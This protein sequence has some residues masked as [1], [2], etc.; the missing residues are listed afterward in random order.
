MSTRNPL[1]LW[2]TP[3][4]AQLSHQSLPTQHLLLNRLLALGLR[5]HPMDPQR[6]PIRKRSPILM[7]I[8]FLPIPLCTLKGS[9]PMDLQP[10][11]MKL[12]LLP[13]DPLLLPM[14]PLLLPMDPLHL[15][16]SPLFPPMD[17]LNLP[18]RFLHLPMDL[19]LLPMKLLLLPM[20]PL[21]LP[22]KPLFLPMDPLHLPMRLLLLPMD[23]LLL[24]MMPLRLPTDPLLLPIKPLLHPMVMTTLFLQSLWSILIENLP[25]L[26]LPTAPQLLPTAPQHP[27][28]TNLSLAM[29]LQP[30][31]MS[32]Q[33]PP[34]LWCIQPRSLI[35][36]ST[37]RPHLSHLSTL[38]LLHFMVSRMR[39]TKRWMSPMEYQRPL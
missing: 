19:P 21:L 32:T 26:L 16:M 15:H 34:T 10:L 14:K 29:F 25:S 7:S 17:H 11:P 9:L 33:Y 8:L 5:H 18:I 39:P 27:C 28:M 1:T 22:M 30:P 20:D 3:A 4:H 37:M 6:L 12:L 23:P 31:P 35:L 36:P 13:M 38:V 24:I 2:N